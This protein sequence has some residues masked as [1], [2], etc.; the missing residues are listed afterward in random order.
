MHILLELLEVRI[1]LVHA[2]DLEQLFVIVVELLSQEQV[3]LLIL[4]ECLIQQ[5]LVKYRLI[6][7]FLKLL[8][9]CHCQVLQVSHK[10][11]KTELILEDKL[12]KCV[13]VR[14]V[15]AASSIEDARLLLVA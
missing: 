14:L 4:F 8:H 9:I 11:V 5:H 15:F 10:I 6:L 2:Q 7:F 13:D 3:L 1:V 12:S